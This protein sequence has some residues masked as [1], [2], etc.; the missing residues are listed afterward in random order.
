MKTKRT[1]F[2]NLE[3]YKLAEQLADE[4]WEI[5]LKWNVLA[6]DTIGKQ[7]VRAA[8]SVGANHCRR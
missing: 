4:V 6:R 7:L 2:E 3:I 5:V 1:N 8:D